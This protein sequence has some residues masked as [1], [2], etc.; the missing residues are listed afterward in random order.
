MT[1]HIFGAIISLL[2][3]FAAF[4][5]NYALAILLS[6]EEYAAFVHNTA[7]LPLI[8]ASIA[9]IALC[10]NRVDGKGIITTSEASTTLL[11][12]AVTA[13]VTSAIALA[14]ATSLPALHT[15]GLWLVM[16]AKFS[17]D[18]ILLSASVLR[19][20]PTDKLIRLVSPV[21]FI[22]CVFCFGDMV[23]SDPIFYFAVSNLVGVCCILNW[24]KGKVDWK[25]ASLDRIWASFYSDKWTVGFQLISLGVFALPTFVF[26]GRSDPEDGAALGLALLSLNGICAFAAL[27]FSH[28]ILLYAQN[29]TFRPSHRRHQSAP[30]F[31]YI[32]SCGVAAAISTVYLLKIKGIDGAIPIGFAVLV[33]AITEISQGVMTA[34]L[35][36]WN[37]KSL[38]WSAIASSI[39]NIIFALQSDNAFNLILGFLFSQFVFFLLPNYGRLRREVSER[40]SNQMSEA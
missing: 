26:V 14:G 27:V 36:R 1:R 34:I 16:G 10:V 31:S 7:L 21:L 37:V 30:L 23:K 25:L 17:I 12:V 4:C 8:T 13:V 18:A 22:A 11:A 6:K 19:Y 29:G 15:I 32:L 20:H 40:F 9:P 2:V 39:S 24:L 33:L 3:V 38:L 28:P 35:I 5:V